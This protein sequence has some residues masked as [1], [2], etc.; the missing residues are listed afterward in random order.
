MG[1][2][3]GLLE[4]KT[5]A[6]PLKLPSNGTLC[7]FFQLSDQLL[8]LDSSAEVSDATS[9]ESERSKPDS[10]LDDVM[11]GLGSVEVSEILTKKTPDLPTTEDLVSS[12][13]MN[14]NDVLVTTQEP[15]PT[16]T[17]SGSFFSIDDLLNDNNETLSTPP[18]VLPSATLTAASASASAPPTKFEQAKQS[19]LRGLDELDLLG[20]SALRAH[21]PQKSPQ[22]AKKNEKLPMNLLQKKMND[23]TKFDLANQDKSKPEVS[24][25]ESFT[26]EVPKPTLDRECPPVKPSAA[27]EASKILP[28]PAPEPEV[29]KD[30]PAAEDVKIADLFVPLASIKPGSDRNY[31]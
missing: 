8:D 22:F 2:E 13:A 7:S 18:L 4:Q 11:I 10:I 16:A 17:T 29:K 31:N 25:R 6:V 9:K 26:P 20:E 30:S 14:T 19:R 24:K 12:S 1:F 28:A 15:T 21:L 27:V 5:D 3:P 23:F